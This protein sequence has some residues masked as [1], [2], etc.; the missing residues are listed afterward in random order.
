[1]KHIA[2]VL[3]LLLPLGLLPVSAAEDALSWR[4]FSYPI[5]TGASWYPRMTQLT[6]GTLLC[7]FDALADGAEETC[8]FVT[9]STD[10]GVRWE[11]AATVVQ[12]PG[13]DCAN[14]NLMQLPKSPVRR[15]C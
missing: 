8:I 7:G 11:Q 1:M 10:G 9:R 12:I 14:A 3:I 5:H 6:D 4:P 2:F 15:W 13:Y